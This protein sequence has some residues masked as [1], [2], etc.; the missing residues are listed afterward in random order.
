MAASMALGACLLVCHVILAA[1]FAVAAVEPLAQAHAHNDYLH[2]RPLLDALD[3]GFT[4]VEAD[5][6]LV[7]GKLLVAHAKRDLKP[8]R[9]LQALYLDPLRERVRKNKGTV[10]PGGGPFGLLID[11]KEDGPAA[12]A[13]LSKMLA[14]YGD[15]VSVVRD[16]TLE[17]K[18]V[19]VVISGDRPIDLIKGEKVRYAGIDGRWGDLDSTE[20]AS[21]LPLVSENWGSHF[22]WR[23]RGPLP[24]AERDKLREAVA[25]AHAHGRKIRF[26]AAPDTPAAWSEL[27]SAGVDLINTDNLAGLETF[28]RAPSTDSGGKTGG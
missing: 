15:I 6:F 20:P 8:Q 25:K 4:S 5:I 9:T 26:W 7:D 1:P 17:P 21:L 3:H 23:G 27:R 24:D 13:V 11:I 16:G 14:D 28:L 2:S 12:Y 18:A 19:N 10:Y 22:K